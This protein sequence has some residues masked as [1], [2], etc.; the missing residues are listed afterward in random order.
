MSRR[1][2]HCIRFKQT[3]SIELLAG[4][5]TI[6]VN[7]VIVRKEATQV[8]SVQVKCVRCGDTRWVDRARLDMRDNGSL[9]LKASA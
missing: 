4:L 8:D 5:M 6:R 3:G 7:G 9:F 2:H 1:Q